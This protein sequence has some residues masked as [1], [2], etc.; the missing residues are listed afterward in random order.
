MRFEIFFALFSRIISH[1]AG[2]ESGKII[3]ADP[4][5][6]ASLSFDHTASAGPILIEPV[7]IV[8]G[9]RQRA[10]KVSVNTW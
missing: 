6:Q 8:F 10:V 4:E 7:Y 1:G 9:Q 2:P 3:K 5:N